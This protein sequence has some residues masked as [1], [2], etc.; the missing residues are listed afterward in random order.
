MSRLP[1]ESH[2]K[3]DARDSLTLEQWKSLPETKA[4]GRWSQEAQLAALSAD[5]LAIL[6]WTLVAVNTE[7]GK[8]PPKPPDPIPR[9]GVG[10]GPLAAVAT[11][12]RRKT[13]RSV[14]ILKLREASQG[15]A[16]TEEQI[17]A[18]IDE[19]IGGGDE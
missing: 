1:S 3:S 19:M 4:W 15:Q 18:Y 5:R 16:P 11:D 17:Q 12:E 9:P 14:A 6:Q 13:I 2:Y 7:K 10:P 8:R